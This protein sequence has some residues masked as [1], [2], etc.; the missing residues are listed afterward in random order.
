M[1]TLTNDN[2]T[3]W[4]PLVEEVALN[5]AGNHTQNY[6][7]AVQTGWLR[8]VELLSEDNRTWKPEQVEGS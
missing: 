6:E 1:K 8:L 7:D 2:L 3:S 4:T 5:Y